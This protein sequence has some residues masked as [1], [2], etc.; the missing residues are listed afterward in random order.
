MQPFTFGYLEAK[1][2]RGGAVRLIHTLHRLGIAEPVDDGDDEAD[3]LGAVAG[4]V[5]GEPTWLEQKVEEASVVEEST[6]PEVDPVAPAAALTEEFAEEPGEEAAETASE[7]LID[8]VT[9]PERHEVLRGVSAP[10]STTLT[11]G[12]YD[13]I[14]RL[15]NKVA[16]R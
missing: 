15:R 14:R 2:G 4:S 1:M 3:L 7:G 12:V 8:P 6:L 11:D 9:V 16:D 10:A 5:S 13:E